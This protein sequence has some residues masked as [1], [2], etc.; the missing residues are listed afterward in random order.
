MESEMPSFL[1]FKK[2]NLKPKK[3]DYVTSESE[4]SA[5]DDDHFYSYSEFISALETIDT[6]KKDIEKPKLEEKEE[7]KKQKL[8][9]VNLLVG[10]FQPFHNG[11]LKMAKFLKEKNGLPS[12]VAVVN[13]GHNK[14]GKSPFNE[15]LIGKYMEAVVKDSPNLIEG[16]FTTKKG[17]LGVIYGIA[18]E[19]GYKVNLIGA[20][21]DRV[22]DYKKQSEY[23]KK[24]G[25]DFPKEIEVVETPRT[26]TGTEIRNSIENEDFLA[27]KKLVPQGVSSFY[28]SLLSS[29]NGKGIKESEEMIT[30]SEILDANNKSLKE[31]IEK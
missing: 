26:T 22:N 4:E 3:V 28:N 29:I 1:D 19:M 10:R 11:H 20:G 31:N 6:T 2:N 8:K 18:K 27:F 21:D 30:E 12:I 24:A 9:D 14:S 13:P 23:L 7:D 25:G 15:D 16:Y 17:L 5:K